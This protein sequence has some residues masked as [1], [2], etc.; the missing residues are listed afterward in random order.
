MSAQI[1][2][3]G[4]LGADPEIRNSNNGTI[5][6]LRVVTNRRRKVGD[7]WEDYDTTWWAVTCFKSTADVAGDLV[8]GQRVLIV[9]WAKENTWTTKDGEK[10]SRIEVVA[11]EVAGVPK[12]GQAAPIAPA[13]DMWGSEAPF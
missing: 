5:V 4:R 3:N 6:S 13:G 12:R 2:L 8:K 9:G 1:T 10:R 7:A 11:D